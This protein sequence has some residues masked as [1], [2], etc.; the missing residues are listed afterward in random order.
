MNCDGGVV[1]NQLLHR[2]FAVFDRLDAVADIAVMFERI[3]QRLVGIPS[4]GGE[5][6]DPTVSTFDRVVS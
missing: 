1:A 6:V 4:F 2:A 5:C 3:Y